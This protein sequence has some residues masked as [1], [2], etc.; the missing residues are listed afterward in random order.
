MAEAGEPGGPA[1]LI[2]G[3]SI[4]SAALR[5]ELGVAIMDPFLFARIDG[6]PHVMVNTLE[7]ARVAAAV[8]DAELYDLNDL[9][10]TELRESGMPYS[11][12]ELELISRAAT[13]MG[14]REAL[15]DP[16]LPIGVA[17]RLR[18][19]G[20]QLTPDAAAFAQRRRAKLDWELDGIRSAQRAAEAGMAAAAELRALG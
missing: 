15:A 8:P 5:H 13:A 17:D 9:G 18:A 14:L 2:F 16:A 4:Q 6:R 3:D 11:E 20:I 10:L 1:L 19:D 12:I 7:R